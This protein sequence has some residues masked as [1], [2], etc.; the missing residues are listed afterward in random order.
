[1]AFDLRKEQRNIDNYIDIDIPATRIR[2]MLRLV[3]VAAGY[4]FNKQYN[5]TN[6]FDFIIEGGSKDV[7][8]DG[9]LTE[10]EAVIKGKSSIT[11]NYKMTCDN[12]N[13][14]YSALNFRTPRASFIQ[15]M[16][17]FVNSKSI[18]NKLNIT[19][20]K[21]HTL[22]GGKNPTLVIKSFYAYKVLDKKGNIVTKKTG[23]NYNFSLKYAGKAESSGKLSS[24]KPKDVSPK[25]TDVWLSPQ[26][27]YNNVISF[28]NHPDSNSIFTSNY[29][30]ESYVEA[31]SNSWNNNTLD[32]KLG[33]AP[34]MSSEFFEVL[35]VLKISKLLSSNNKIIKDVVGWPEE[36]RITKVEIYLPEAANEALIDYKIAVNGNRNTPLKISVKS[37]MR[38]SST[39]TVKFQTAF[40]GGEAEVH[41]WFKS[42]ASNARS[43]QIGQRMIAS[44]AMEYNKYSSKGTLY[45]IRG[46]R[47][48]L[49]GSKKSQVTS[50]FKQVLN[51]SSMSVNEWNQVL[52]ILDKKITSINKNFEPLDNLISDP[53][54]LLKTKNFIADNLFKEES[55]TKK[56]KECISLTEEE[57]VKRSPNKKYPFA[58]NNVA[59]LCER[60]L[61]QTSYETGATQ[62][63]FYKLFYEQVLLKESVLYSITKQKE[64]N[65]EMRLYY[66]FVSTRNFGQYKQWIKLRTK[67]YANNMQDALGMGV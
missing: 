28:I 63:N 41:K 19:E 21:L 32:D 35:S 34:D 54:L 62:I 15:D 45:P 30:R 18:K 5:E 8:E 57:A 33:V 36:E 24:L 31:V 53:G 47:K 9:T 52:T 13:Q 43:S 1:M 4:A 38:G 14:K 58:L 55:K 44:S 16:I 7:D 20:I 10:I 2:R 51:T 23:I 27:F 64:I 46:L 60:V 65:N 61:V 42:I 48:L 56:V 29:L 40:P 66:D 12:G 3:H 67:N 26:Q 6:G 39:A 49:A 17:S 22:A 25:I 37:Q 59:L 11:Y 50:D